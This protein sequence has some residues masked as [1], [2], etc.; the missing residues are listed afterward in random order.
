MT[1]YSLYDFTL[2]DGKV[3]ALLKIGKRSKLEPVTLSRRDA[4]RLFRHLAAALEVAE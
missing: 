4:W 2:Q 3:V 1:D